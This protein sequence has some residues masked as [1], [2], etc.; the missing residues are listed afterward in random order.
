MQN[1]E[2]LASQKEQEFKSSYQNLG[3]ENVELTE[4]SLEKIANDSIDK[5]FSYL[6]DFTERPE[7]NTNEITRKAMG[8]YLE[9]K[10]FWV[11]FYG[12]EGLDLALIQPDNFDIDEMIEDA[13]Y[14]KK[15]YVLKKLG[16]R[17]VEE[18]EEKENRPLTDGEKEDLISKVSLDEKRIG[19][20]ES[21]LRLTDTEKKRAQESFS[22]VKEFI[23][24]P[25][26]KEI[27]QESIEGLT[28][29][30]ELSESDKLRNI[31]L[32]KV[33]LQLTGNKTVLKFS[34]ERKIESVGKEQEEAKEE[35]VEKEKP[36][37]ARSRVVGKVTEITPELQQY[38]RKEAQK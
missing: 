18:A 20:I 9:G 37:L 23:I 19:E 31:I 3:S 1:S 6:Q 12:E 4:D 7:A 32:L 17:A 30:E 35:L 27:I 16:K 25:D 21:S 11:K 24:N 5:I 34:K 28:E 29:D 2:E 15:Y 8:Y 22:K 36:R 13:I 38:L 33:L 14:Q 26:K 10:G